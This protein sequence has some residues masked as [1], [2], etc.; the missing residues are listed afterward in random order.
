M[1]TRVMKATLEEYAYIYVKLSSLRPLL[2]TPEELGTKLKSYKDLKPLKTYIQQ[3]Y[4]TFEPIEESVLEYEWALW[5][6]YF[7]I[8]EKMIVMAPMAIQILVKTFL[9][10][11]EIWNLKIAIYG[12]LQKTGYE[13]RYGL[14]Y[15]RPS[16]ILDRYEFLGELLRSK[17]LS[18]IEQAVMNTPYQRIVKEGLEKYEETGEIFFLEQELDKFYFTNLMS[19]S[20]SFPPEEKKFLDSFISQQIDYYTLNIIYRALY[21]KIPREI[22]EPYLL[23]N[24]LVFTKQEFL[25][26]SKSKSMKTFFTTMGNILQHKKGYDFILEKL[27]SRDPRE[28]GKLS[29]Q[30]LRTFIT[31]FQHR[32]IGDIPL[33]SITLI[34]QMLLAKQLEIQEIY[35][36][37]V[38]IALA[39]DQP[40]REK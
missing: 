31:R 14:V 37:V 20:S 29:K 28:W 6:A 4:P 17:N 26:L 12:V 25:E 15:D 10:K 34:F 16:I 7:R 40:D 23:F 11:Y 18:E 33:R 9:V 13:T 8:I 3:F 36:R 32:I 2:M 30:L 35:A 22:I 5:D 1:K 24:G 38:Q 19:R 39:T 21:N 27:A